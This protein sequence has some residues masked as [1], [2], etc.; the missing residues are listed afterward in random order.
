MSNNIVNIIDSSV[1]FVR[2]WEGGTRAGF[3]VKDPCLLLV[4]NF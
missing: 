3:K 2:E 4:E 1:R